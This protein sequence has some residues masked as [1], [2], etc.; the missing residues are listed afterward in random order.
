MTF[1]KRKIHAVSL[2]VLSLAVFSL[3]VLKAAP[4]AFSDPGV[5]S[6]PFEGLSIQAISLYGSTDILN[7][8]EGLLPCRE[9]RPCLGGVV[10]HHGLAFPMIVRFYETLARGSLEG[11]AGIGR[12]FILSP[13]HFRQVRNHAAIC[14]ED[15]GLSERVL[16]AD[17]EAITALSSL[18]IVEEMP[19][20]CSSEHGITIHIP[21]TAAY[22]P[23]ARVVPLLLNARIPDPALLTIRESMKS[24]FSN[25][26]LLILSM[27]LS[28]Y[29][30]PELM[31]LEDEKTLPVLTG[32]RAYDTRNLDI[33]ARRAAHLSLLL[34]RDEG[35]EEGIV[36]E[37]RDSTYF[38]GHRVES[39][40]SYASVLYPRSGRSKAEEPPESTAVSLVPILPNNPPNNPAQ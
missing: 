37:H 13:D 6:S 29:K 18:S 22:F 36:T 3:T 40:T 30:T 5:L 32:L 39:G 2:S 16:K 17:S 26:T 31:A 1:S 12:V 10:P 8:P 14:P 33:D 23:Q 27:D 4:P 11:G 25:D 28:H 7:R 21:M 15:W 19:G 34:F 38:T 24:L 20:I 35:A 9:G